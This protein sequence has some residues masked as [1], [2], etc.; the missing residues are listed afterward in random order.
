MPCRAGQAQ[1]YRQSIRFF[2]SWFKLRFFSVLLLKQWSGPGG[3]KLCDNPEKTGPAVVVPV[4][5]RSFMIV[6]MIDPGSY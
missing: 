6:Q 4:P 2:L 5:K 3:I 1:I